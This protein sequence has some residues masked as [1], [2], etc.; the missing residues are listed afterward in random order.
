MQKSFCVWVSSF[1]EKE[2]DAY[3]EWQ[4]VEE[5]ILDGINS[6]QNR[7]NYLKMETRYVRRKCFSTFF[8]KI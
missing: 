3:K 4:S 7:N 8:E 5:L 1:S 2:K 6:I